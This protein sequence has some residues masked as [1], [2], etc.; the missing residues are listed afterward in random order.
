MEYMTLREAA[1]FLR[2]SRETIYRMIYRKEIP[3]Y[4]VGKKYLFKKEELV[5]C[6]TLA[7]TQANDIAGK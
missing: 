2:I 1:K 5:K 6:L 3:F 7:K 4:R